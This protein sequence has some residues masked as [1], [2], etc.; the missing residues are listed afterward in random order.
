MKKGRWLSL[1]MGILF[2]GQI[3]AAGLNLLLYQEEIYLKIQAED[4]VLSSFM[5]GEAEIA[6]NFEALSGYLRFPAVL[7]GEVLALPHLPMSEN[8]RAHFYEVKLWFRAADV[9]FV[10]FGA[11][12]L[13][14]RRLAGKRGRK[15][16][17]G[18]MEAAA[19]GLA[20]VLAAG[21]AVDF[22]TFF[23]GFHRALFSND[24]WQMDPFLDPVALYLPESYFRYC[25]LFLAG[26][27]AV[28]IGA[29]EA[30]RQMKRFRARAALSRI[31]FDR[32]Q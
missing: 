22:H 6:D 28:G 18:W 32:R 29:L 15:F 8:G 19:G 9:M 26:M 25:G 16:C 21:A 13:L 23:T 11:F 4:K 24:Y 30:I 12:Q 2:F 20:L 1:M 10:C 17:L 5:L 14:L 27:E 31:D 7:N 3:L